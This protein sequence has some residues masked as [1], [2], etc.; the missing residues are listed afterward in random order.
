[1]S[2]QIDNPVEDDQMTTRAIDTDTG[3]DERREAEDEERRDEERWGDDES[4][5]ARRR[6]G[7]GDDEEPIAPRPRGR[8]LRPLPLAL[9]AVAIAAAGFIGGVEAQKRSE[10]GGG[11]G[12]LPGGAELPAVMARGITPG[13]ESEGGSTAGGS[14]SEGGSGSTGEA[15][16]GSPTFGGAEAAATGT[17]T[18]VEGHTIYVKESDGTVVAVKAGDGSTV[19]RD[20]NVAA[21][22]VHP[23]DSVVVQ[24]SKHGSTVRASSIAATE[25]GVESSLAFGGP[26][27][28]S[29]ASGGEGDSSED[30]A[31]VESLFE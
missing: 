17:V 15:A 21:K 24:G 20:S 29:S 16:T 11:S 27:A 5:T 19:T 10:G 22:K 18:S 25:S 8:L 9:L 4:G 28:A 2:E 31:S 26:T 23:G 3:D 13:G 30:E 1:L 12:S 6:G 7:W 14:E